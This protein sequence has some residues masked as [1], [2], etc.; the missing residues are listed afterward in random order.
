MQNAKIPLTQALMIYSGAGENYI[1]IHQVK[2]GE[3]LAGKPLTRQAIRQVWKTCYEKVKAASKPG[4][5]PPNLLYHHGNRLIWH[6]P[7]GRHQ[8]AFR[9]ELAIPSGMAHCPALIF[10]ST[11]R[12]LDLFAIKQRGRPSAKT[13]LYRAPFHNVGC[14]GGVCLGSARIP[15]PNIP[16]SKYI[17]GMEAA[18][19]DSEFSH[20][21]GESPLA[22]KANINTLWKRLIES[23]DR[24]PNKV[25]RDTGKRLEDLL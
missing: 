25:L 21:N 8:L 20:T 7:A 19:W 4:L 5:L 22:G 10:D 16:V 24:F 12:G 18:F 11:G 9:K 17:A 15:R 2:N 1:E 6:I 23:G 13:K 14:R 3:L